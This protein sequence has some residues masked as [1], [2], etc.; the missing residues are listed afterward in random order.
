MNVSNWS[1]FSRPNAAPD[2]VNNAFRELF[3]T[4]PPRSSYVCIYEYMHVCFECMYA[5][6]HV[7]MILY[8]S[9]YVNRYVCRW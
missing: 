9:I 7:C 4:M 1:L 6:K 5:L 8:E 3:S 2:A